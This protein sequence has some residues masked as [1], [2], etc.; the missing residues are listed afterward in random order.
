MRFLDW[1]WL[2]TYKTKFWSHKINMLNGKYHRKMRSKNFRFSTM[3]FLG[4]FSW[5]CPFLGLFNWFRAKTTW[6][7]HP[8]EF[9][10]TKNRIS[11]F[12]NFFFEKAFF[13]KK[14]FF[15][16]SMIFQDFFQKTRNH[17]FWVPKSSW[18]CS[19]SGLSSKPIEKAKKWANLGKNTQ[20]FYS[21]KLENFRPWF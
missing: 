5:I 14:I 9:W 4:F 21:W 12:L 16:F 8:T 20:K 11:G 18:M 1:I 7:T 2:F 6:E 10:S 13:I 17:F 19:P 15:N 3:E